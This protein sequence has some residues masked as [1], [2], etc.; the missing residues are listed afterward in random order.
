MYTLE[1]YTSANRYFGR[2]STSMHNEAFTQHCLGAWA[3]RAS[4]SRD[5][6]RTIKIDVPRA[7]FKDRR[8]TIVA[9]QICVLPNSLT[10][11]PISVF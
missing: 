7:N 10:H 3:T 2:V 1:F 6:D 4:G 5:L 11:G 9:R 8:L